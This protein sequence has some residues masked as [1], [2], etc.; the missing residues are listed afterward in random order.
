M[1]IGDHP[2][3]CSYCPWRQAGTYCH[4]SIPYVC[5]VCNGSGTPGMKP[6]DTAV[7]PGTRINCPACSGTGVVWPAP[8]AEARP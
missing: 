7:C 6:A 2:D 3:H 8:R 5:P 1:A 4:Q